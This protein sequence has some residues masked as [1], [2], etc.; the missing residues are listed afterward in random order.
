MLR[1]TLA[2]FAV[3]GLATASHAGDMDP[4]ADPGWEFMLAPYFWAA[5][6]EGNLDA[7]NVSADIDVSF[8]D[9]WDALDV[10]VL[11][12]FEARNGRFSVATN[13][14]Y[15]KLSAD[16]ERPISS[17]LPGAPP[18]SFDVRS[19]LEEIIFELFP[20]F[21][22]LSL[23]LCD[24]SGE[25]RIALDLGPGARAFW[26]NT[27][28]DVKLDP[29]SPLGPFSRRFDERNFWVDLVG[30][31][32]V[33]AQLT[34]NVRFVVAGDYGGFDIGS[35]SHKTWSLQGYLDYRLGR[36][37][38]LVGGWRTLEIERGSVELEMAGPLFGAA[39]RF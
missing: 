29:G 5:G 24:A 39:Y 8:S 7:E 12:A 35:S 16:A 6:I 3:L 22:V 23:P 21:E 19:T 31:A 13:A 36:H 10:G 17:V 33:R 15:L 18:G 30:T 14:I 32:R 34:E 26:L 27:H 25:R 20:R 11:T 9:I 37:W 38:T 4:G 28:L 2:T 1:T